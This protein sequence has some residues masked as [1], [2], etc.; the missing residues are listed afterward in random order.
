MPKIRQDVQVFAVHLKAAYRDQ[1]ASEIAALK[2]PRIVV[3]EVGRE[4]KF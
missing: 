1:V 4:Y 2:D 3:A